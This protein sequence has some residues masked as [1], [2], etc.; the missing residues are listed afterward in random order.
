VYAPSSILFEKRRGEQNGWEER[1]SERA[2][3]SERERE[4]EREGTSREVRKAKEK[5][6]KKSPN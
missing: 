6:K 1:A 5:W 4:R 3:A 2:S